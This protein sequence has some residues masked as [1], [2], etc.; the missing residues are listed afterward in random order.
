MATPEDPVEVVLRNAI[1]LARLTNGVVRDTEQILLDLIERIVAELTRVDPTAVSAASYRQARVDRVLE[2]VER[3]AGEG[4][5]DW[6]RQVR[7][8]VAQIGAQQSQA[9]TAV[10]I[11]SVGGT[12]AALRAGPTLNSVKAIIDRNPFLGDTLARWTQSQE[13]AMVRGVRRQVQLGMLREESIDQLV[14]RVRG[15]REGSRVVGGV[16]R[17]TRSNAEAVV[18]TAV[19]DVA[20]TAAF[21]TYSGNPRVSKSYQYVATLD[22]ATTLICISLDGSIHRYDDSA[23]PRPPQHFRCRSIIVPTVDWE[24]LGITPPAD[25]ERIARNPQTG[26][27]EYIPARENYGDWLRRQ[28]DGIQARILGPERARLFR[29]GEIGIRDLTRDGRVLRLDEL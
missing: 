3:M 28:P 6:K 21:E 8:A 9:A 29:E 16:W 27:R 26:K 23:A 18:R 5:A 14:R 7:Q 15:K 1:R 22:D 11:A 4:F 20:N 12:Q 25:G 10:L 13:E 19:T 2:A 24:A 17:T